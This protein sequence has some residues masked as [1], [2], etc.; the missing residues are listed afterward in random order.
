MKDIHVSFEANLFKPAVLLLW[1][2]LLAIQMFQVIHSPL[3]FDDAWMANYA[4]GWAQGTGYGLP[5]YDKFYA[6]CNAMISPVFIWTGWGALFIAVFGNVYWAPALAGVT[7]IQLLLIGCFFALR[8]TQ[9]LKTH[10]WKISFYGLLL[11]VLAAT[12]NYIH[13]PEYSFLWYSF[14]GDIISALCVI[15]P[16]LLLI[17]PDKSAKHYL[18][19]GAL[20]GVASQVKLLTLLPAVVIYLG[21][22]LRIRKEACFKTAAYYV[23]LMTLGPV[24]LIVLW[25][26]YAIFCLGLE[27]VIA[28]FTNGFSILSNVAL[29]VHQTVRSDALVKYGPLKSAGGLWLCIGVFLL[30][31]VAILAGRNIAFGLKQKSMGSAEYYATCLILCSIILDLWWVF[32][33]VPLYR[34]LA[35]SMMYM[36]PGLAILLT[37]RHQLYPY[38][39]YVLTALA[40]FGRGDDA[41]FALLKE[42]FRTHQSRDDLVKAKET[43]EKLQQDGYALSGCGVNF[44]MEYLLPG[45]GH[46]APCDKLMTEKRK[47]ALLES[48]VK[49]NTIAYYDV[50]TMTVKLAP[51]PAWVKEKCQ[52]EFPSP[53]F[54][55]WICN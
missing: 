4:K 19:I 14:H 49:P 37:L 9:E 24:L 8:T 38:S 42:G 44:E 21:V 5:L 7:A 18:L 12:G 6:F 23:F 48:Y 13:R 39:L 22:F 55:V 46:F 15:L 20:F 45:R 16:V 35:T 11:C 3:S 31:C 33:S 40:I 53:Y 25:E 43:L 32:F 1:A 54:A 41:N 34:Y 28:G 36:M 30:P 27:G 52:P 29:H 51:P 47:F 2:A 26:I 17:R 50:D 10:L